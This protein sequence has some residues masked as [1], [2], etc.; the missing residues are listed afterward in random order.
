[1]HVYSARHDQVDALA[2]LAGAAFEN[3]PLHTAVIPALN[4]AQSF[5][6]WVRE[7]HRVMIK[8]FIRSHTVLVLEDKGEILGVALLNRR[9]PGISAYLRYCT[10]LFGYMRFDRLV[11]FFMFTEA[12]DTV[13]RR[14]SDFDWFLTVIAVGPK[15]QGR[16]VGRR[17]LEKGI[18]GYIRSR[19]GGRLAFI[20][21]TPVN[22][23][24]YS[25]AG[26]TLIGEHT[27][28]FEE[29]EVPVWSFEKDIL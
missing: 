10:P 25:S 7:I 13:V 15:Q 16:G 14:E 28:T 8:I 23:R 27:V 29:N 22:A 5:P 9:P 19:G 21:C 11:R 24:F 26:Y 12:A 6:Q 3:Y 1:M 18:E 4:S 20:T 17:F 2:T